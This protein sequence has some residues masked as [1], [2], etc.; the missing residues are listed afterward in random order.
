MGISNDLPLRHPLRFPPIEEGSLVQDRPTL[1]RMPNARSRRRWF[2]LPAIDALSASAAVLAVAGLAGTDAFPVLPA[3][4]LLLVAL[5][6]ALGLYGP[7]AQAGLAGEGHGPAVLTLRILIAAALAWTTSLMTGLGAGAQ[8]GLWAGFLALDGAMRA[9]AGPLLRRLEVPERWI[10]VGDEDIAA[11]LEAFGPL[12]RYAS[13][14]YRISPRQTEREDRVQAL[15]VVDGHGADRV[16]IGSSNVDDDDQL[17]DLVRS[18][19]SLGVPV[20]LLPRPLDLLEP[21]SVT[22]SAVGGVPLIEVAGLAARGAVPYTGPDRRRERRT[23]VSVVVPAVNE[24]LNIGEVLRRLPSDLHEVILVDGNSRDD[25]I[26]VARRAY[27]GIKV[28]TQSGR[29]KGDAL[30]TGFAAVTGNLVVTLDADGSADPAEI[31]RFVAALEQGADFAKGSRFLGDGGSSDITG[32]RRVGNA[33]LSGTANTLHGTRFTDLCYGYNA[34]WA[35]CLP[36]I[37]LDVPGFEVET[38][39]NLRV[40]GA[41]LRVTEVPSYES[42]RI[43][44][45]SNLK[46]FRDGVRVLNT[47]IRE[48][49]HHAARKPARKPARNGTAALPSQPLADAAE[50]ET[51]STR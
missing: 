9:A 40:A 38:L 21:R 4:P 15:Q 17:L 44:G 48:A 24:E 16:V 47:I 36:F 33:F 31:P 1:G 39:I 20:S 7:R 3:A 11:R 8:L 27:P 23:K 22:A 34:F 28:L 26:G 50:A 10:L 19:R 12:K 35:R 5:S 14:I 29:G 46:T 41:G 43:S 51:V 18:F 30:R 49:R 25:T 6:H 13:V 32:V 42:P 2:V 37:S 45:E